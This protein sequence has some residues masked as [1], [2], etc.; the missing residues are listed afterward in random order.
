MS[1]PPG[2]RDPVKMREVLM[3]IAKRLGE[4]PVQAGELVRRRAE[5]SDALHRALDALKQREVEVAGAVASERNGD[6]KPAY[7]NEQARAAEI[8]KRLAADT[9][10]TFA[11]AEAD[12][13]RQ[14]LRELDA[15]IE[16]TGRRHRSDSNMAYL[17]AS[18][19][20]AGLTADAEAVLTAYAEG[21]CT[22][23]Q[24]PAPTQEAQPAAPQAPAGSGKSKEDG[25][26]TGTFE[27]LEV[28][29]GS[30]EGTIRAYCES[31]T[32][33]KIAVYAKNGEGRTLASAIGRKVELKYRRVDRGLFAVS[34]RP[35]A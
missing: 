17:V 4:V 30:K 8:A 27:V 6:G 33:G 21:A 1:G 29:P 25:L 16:E 31:E 11:K 7:P 18:L 5:I 12:L 34:V 19:L 26:E 20:N 13:L 24:V 28:R 9:G 15:R 22:P 10:Y 3:E 35:V 32:T 23:T 14:E 2:A